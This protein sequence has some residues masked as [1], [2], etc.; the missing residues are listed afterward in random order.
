MPDDDFDIPR[1]ADYLHLAVADVSRLAER[2]KLPGRKV[3]GQWRFSPADIHHWLEDRIGLSDEAELQRMEGFLRPEEEH[4]DGLQSIAEMLPLAAIE[5]PLAARTRN[6]VITSMAEAAARTGLLW[7]SQK[8]ADAVRA[9]EDMHST[10]LESGVAL[11][12]PRRPMVTILGEALLA[13]G[14]TEKAVP[15]GGQGLTSDLF[16]LICSTDDRG[17]LQA[18]ARLSRLISDAALLGSLR[19][20]TTAA[21]VHKAIETAEK[22]IATP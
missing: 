22:K 4:H 3:Q 21:E 18:L 13:F 2:G 17:H 15:F 5:V 7:D 1:L 12:H 10:A 6:S 11:L 16:F 14:R 19:Q 20:A 8:M 9:R